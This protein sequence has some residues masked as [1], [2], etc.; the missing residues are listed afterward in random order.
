MLA[1]FV[2]EIGDRSK[3]AARDHIALDLSKPQ[4]HREFPASV[5]DAS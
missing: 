3:H 5:R 2:A 4:F 1:E